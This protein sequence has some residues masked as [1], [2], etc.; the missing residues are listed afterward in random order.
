MKIM[1]PKLLCNLHTNRPSTKFVD[2][3]GMVIPQDGE[4]PKAEI[5]GY[6]F[7]REEIA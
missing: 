2:K 1:E 3:E 7:E 4:E 5:P 6:C